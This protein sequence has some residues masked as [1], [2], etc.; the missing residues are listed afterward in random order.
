[1]SAVL[2]VET[3]VLRREL[4]RVGLDVVKMQAKYQKF[5]AICDTLVSLNN[6]YKQ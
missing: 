3:A 2:V 4:L 5:T 6:P 1:M